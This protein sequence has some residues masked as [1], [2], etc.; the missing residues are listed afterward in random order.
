MGRRGNSR[1]SIS[2]FPAAVIE[3]KEEFVW[4]DSLR[5]RESALA[6]RYGSKQYGKY[7][8]LRDHTFYHTYKQ[9]KPRN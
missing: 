4:T 9:R 7:R 3:H 2:H 8:K 1:H 5:W 6:R